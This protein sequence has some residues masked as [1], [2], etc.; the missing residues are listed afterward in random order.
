MLVQVEIVVAM[1]FSEISLIEK[2]VDIVLRDV[3]KKLQR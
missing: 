1:T 2:R 3:N